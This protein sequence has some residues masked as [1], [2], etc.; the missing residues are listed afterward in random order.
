M[1]NPNSAAARMGN[2]MRIRIAVKKMFQVKIGI[3]N[4]VTPARA[5]R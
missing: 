2:A 3:R 1:S 5:R 4:I